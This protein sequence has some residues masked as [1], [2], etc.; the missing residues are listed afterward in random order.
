M[1]GRVCAH[2]YTDSQRPGETILSHGDGLKD[3]Y[4]YEPPHMN[5]GNPT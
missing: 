3:R 4:E 5:D 2:V 1:F